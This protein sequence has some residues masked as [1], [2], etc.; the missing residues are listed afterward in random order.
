MNLRAHAVATI[1]GKMA[2]VKPS[3]KV[4]AGHLPPF[5]W[6]NVA[7]PEPSLYLWGVGGWYS[8]ETIRNRL[9]AYSRPV[10]SIKCMSSVI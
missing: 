1:T 8:K 9:Q 10:G 4:P 5:R 3:Y 2:P 7:G 6:H